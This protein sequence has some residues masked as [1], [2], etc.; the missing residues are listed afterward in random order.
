MFIHWI[1]IFFSGMHFAKQ[2]YLENLSRA[3]I[4][5]VS[6]RNEAFESDDWNRLYLIKSLN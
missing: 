2:L 4:Y 3:Y 6:K 1:K 5:I